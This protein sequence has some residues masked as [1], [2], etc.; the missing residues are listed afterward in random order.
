MAHV[1]QQPRHAQ[2]FLHTGEGRHIAHHS[3]Q[4]G[5]E[6]AGPFAAQVHGAQ[7]VLKARVLS[8]GEDPPGR[9]E[10]VD[11]AQSLQPRV[12]EQVLLRGNALAADALRD[13]DVAKQRIGHQ[14]HCLVL[15][16]EIRHES[17]T[18]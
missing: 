3:G 15:A 10:L 17:A 5:I 16:S 12:I 18:F 7:R 14:V 2:R 6:P 13:L 9:L 4:I 11:A 8:A 1:M